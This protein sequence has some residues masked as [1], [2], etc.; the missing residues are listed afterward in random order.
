MGVPPNAVNYPN[1]ANW[2]Y[3]QCSNCK[4]QVAFSYPT[5]PASSSMFISPAEISNHCEFCGA[6]TRVFVS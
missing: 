3:Y 5:T 6:D 2:T 1:F 4:V